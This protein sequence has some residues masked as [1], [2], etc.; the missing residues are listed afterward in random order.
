MRVE[1]LE[2]YVH[3]QRSPYHDFLSSIKE[4]LKQAKKF[5]LFILR[6]FIQ[7]IFRKTQNRFIHSI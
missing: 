3:L 7:D 1:M 2:K 4:F 5:S 6:K